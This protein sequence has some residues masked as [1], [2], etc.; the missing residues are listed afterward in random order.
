MTFWSRGQQIVWRW[1]DVTEPHFAETLTVVRDDEDGLL[2]W[3]AA[4]TPVLRVGRADGLGLRE[5]PATASTAPRV[6]V[7]GVWEGY[8]VLRVAPAGKPWSV[9]SF[10][11]EGSRTFEG[12]YVNIEDPHTRVGTTTYTRDRI[13]D[14]EVEPDRTVYRKDVD[15]LALAVEQGRYSREEADRFMRW[16]EQAEAMVAAWASPMCDGWEDF[17]PD[18][19]WPVPESPP[20]H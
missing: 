3:L 4:G 20:A 5:D 13:V 1:G 11:T 17:R 10:F 7:E 2:A 8:D 18:P 12:W 14:L 16:L 19:A 9:W 6:Q 15:E